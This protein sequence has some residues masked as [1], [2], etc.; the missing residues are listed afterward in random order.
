MPG[1]RTI[2]SAKETLAMVAPK[3]CLHAVDTFSSEERALRWMRQPLAELGE[4][5]PEDVLLADGQSEA[6]QA[7]LGRIDYGVCG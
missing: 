6:V 3:I 5:T 2:K 1:L 4:R 7:I